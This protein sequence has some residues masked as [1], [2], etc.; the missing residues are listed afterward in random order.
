[1]TGQ[2]Q[3][4]GFRAYVARQAAARGVAGWVRNE[5]DGSVVAVVEG[6]GAAVAALLDDLRAGPRSAVVDDV[7]TSDTTPEGL[8]DFSVR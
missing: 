7:A 4:V 5:P 2:V 3:G 1:M 8:T 6:P